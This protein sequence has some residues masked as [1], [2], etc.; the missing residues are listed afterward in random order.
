MKNIGKVERV[1]VIG[2]LVV[3][4]LILVVAI[5]G[6]NEVEDA[7]LEDELARTEQPANRPSLDA[8]QPATKL[9]KDRRLVDFG[10][11]RAKEPRGNDLAGPG[12]AGRA[13][14]LAETAGP[15]DPSRT[16]RER[17]RRPQPTEGERASPPPTNEALPA[18]RAENLV[19][20][21]SASSLLARIEDKMAG[22]DSKPSTDPGAGSHP[23]AVSPEKDAGPG[24]GLEPGKGA[25]RD[26][27][28]RD[29]GRR[30]LP[31]ARGAVPPPGAQ[32]YYVEA[33]DSLD[34]IAR[35]LYGTDVSWQEI[36]A[37]NP[38][39]T[40]PGRIL[41]GQPLNLPRPVKADLLSGNTVPPGVPALASMTVPSSG[42]SLSGHALLRPPMKRL[43]NVTEYSVQKGDTL[44]SI[45][46]AHYGS[47]SAWREIL[48]A[49]SDRIIGKDRIRVGQTLLLP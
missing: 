15:A 7:M 34:R 2:I 18:P 13:T 20:P 16:E 6:A 9:E 19:T 39:L 12:Q 4:G 29:G 31:G 1:L 22:R 49:N 14:P 35:K 21:G 24:R 43:S 3:I 48:E 27:I 5:K 25:D 8:S 11:N 36:F 42:H 40:D 32:K 17:K 41:V 23:E 46:L 47:K 26:G 10:A 38:D 37:A 28:L 33:G 30:D 45:A 44:M